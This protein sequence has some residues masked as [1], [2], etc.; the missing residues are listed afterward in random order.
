MPTPYDG[1]TMNYQNLTIFC[2]QYINENHTNIS[3]EI[4]VQLSYDDLYYCLN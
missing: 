3:D 4:F 2:L 1:W